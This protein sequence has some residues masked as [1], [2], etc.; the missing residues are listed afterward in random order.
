MSDENLTPEPRGHA[1]VYSFFN[2]WE[3]P[4]R[5]GSVHV[6]FR[7]RFPSKLPRRVY[8][9]IGA[10]V[11]AVVGRA[12]LKKIERVSAS[13][14]LGLAPQGCISETELAKY[15]ADRDTVGV[16]HMEGFEFFDHPVSAA[17][18]STRIAFS[19]PQN[20]QNLS[21]EDEEMLMEMGR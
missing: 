1:V 7:N 18:I 21:A 4:L 19:P 12:K 16:I 11:M 2:K 14:A 5:S 8:F 13:Q 6:F 15:M 9:Y 20:F 3:A 17:D 10:P